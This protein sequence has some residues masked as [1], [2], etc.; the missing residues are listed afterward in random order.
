MILP[1]CLIS[2]TH[3]Y[4]P[5]PSSEDTSLEKSLIKLFSKIKQEISFPEFMQFVNIVC[6]YKGKGD[7]MDLQ[8]D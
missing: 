7:K 1:Y 5:C 4:F 2:I 8:N 3:D 6:I